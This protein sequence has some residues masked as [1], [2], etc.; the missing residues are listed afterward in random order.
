MEP[1]IWRCRQLTEDLELYQVAS[2]MYGSVDFS[3]GDL[4]HSPRGFSG[5]DIPIVQLCGSEVR[6]H[7]FQAEVEAAWGER[8][9]GFREQKSFINE[10]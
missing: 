8:S 5:L 1:I 4:R 2:A 10:D 7:S 9:G 3:G 6:G